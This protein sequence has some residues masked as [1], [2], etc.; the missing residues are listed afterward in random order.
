MTISCRHISKTTTRVFPPLHPLSS[1]HRSKFCGSLC[2]SVRQNVPP[3]TLFRSHPICLDLAIV[4][5]SLPLCTYLHLYVCVHVHVGIALSRLY[6]IDILPSEPSHFLLCINV[7]PPQSMSF[8]LFLSIVHCVTKMR[9]WIAS[10]FLSDLTN[11][12]DRE[13]WG[14]KCRMEDARNPNN[15]RWHLDIRTA[16]KRRSPQIID[17]RSLP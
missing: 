11:F 16:N 15:D 12:P 13:Q 8:P 17:M 9:K 3:R 14:V 6:I 2:T 7:S 10:R 4:F 5:L 1:S